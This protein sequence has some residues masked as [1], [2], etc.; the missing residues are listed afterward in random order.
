MIYVPI[1]REA[2]QRRH[3]ELAARPVALQL[4]WPPAD[5]SQGRQLDI[6]T[7]QRLDVGV[8]AA[9]VWLGDR[10]QFGQRQHAAGARGLEGR[11]VVRGARVTDQGR[12]RER[13][14]ATDQEV[15]TDGLGQ[16]REAQRAAR[17][18]EA[19]TINRREVGIKHR[20]AVA[21]LQDGHMIYVPI[22]G[23]TGQRRHVEPAARPVALQLHRSPAD[24]GQDRQLDIATGQ[25]LDLGVRAASVWLGDRGQFGQRQ[26]AAGARGLEG[27]RVVRGARV[28]GQGRKSQRGPAADQE[29]G[30]VGLGQCREA[31]RTARYRE[32]ASS[33]TG[34]LRGGQ[35][36]GGVE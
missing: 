6:A 23:D 15:G 12:Q 4:H 25:R 17:Y 19:H 20:A 29:V 3:V 9:S 35:S 5:L 24:L 33:E 31:Q 1:A 2:T 13:S 34:N 28:T 8:R 32:R 18:R 16:C 21:S 22:A 10:G 7:G 11:R 30:T 14:P 27:R 36:R 26:H